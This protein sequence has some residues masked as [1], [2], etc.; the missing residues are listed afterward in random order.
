MSRQTPVVPVR[1]IKVEYLVLFST[2]TWYM[3]AVLSRN[4]ENAGLDDWT[5]MSHEGRVLHVS[6]G[7]IIII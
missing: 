1:G 5:Q 2:G 4:K 7:C 3:G 6:G